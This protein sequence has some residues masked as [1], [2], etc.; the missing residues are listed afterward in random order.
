MRRY[1]HEFP[2]KYLP[3]FLEYLDM[4]EAEFFDIADNARSP[5]LWTRTDN[6]WEL[7]HRVS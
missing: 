4:S 2:R 3:E 6:A 1:D 5:H 7:R